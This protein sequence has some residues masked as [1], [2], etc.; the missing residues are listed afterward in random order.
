MQLAP[1]RNATTF[2]SKNGPRRIHSWNVFLV[3]ANQAASLPFKTPDNSP[4]FFYIS[5]RHEAESSLVGVRRDRFQRATRDNWHEVRGN[6]EEHLLFPRLTY[7]VHFAHAWRHG[8]GTTDWKIVVAS[9]RI[10]A[11][12]IPC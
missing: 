10:L 5:S 7:K 4:L 9:W 12:G 6:G 11:R 8:E 3:C 1:K 2:P